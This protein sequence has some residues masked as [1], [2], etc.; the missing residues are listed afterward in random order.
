MSETAGPKKNVDIVHLQISKVDGVNMIQP[1][2]KRMK[3]T[4]EALILLQ[5]IHGL[6]R[7]MKM[8][9]VVLLKEG[10][11]GI[12]FVQARLSS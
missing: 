12:F 2:R 7:I 4:D 10:T 9:K 11:V 1:R 3:R 5:I 8:T 6:R